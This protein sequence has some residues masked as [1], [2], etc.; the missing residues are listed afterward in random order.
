M[1]KINFPGRANTLNT[2][3][4]HTDGC[5]RALGKHR[6]VSHTIEKHILRPTRRRLTVLEHV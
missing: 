5:E 2:A 1:S 4:V 6:Q 3:Q